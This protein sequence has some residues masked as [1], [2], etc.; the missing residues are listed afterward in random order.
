MLAR[1]ISLCDHPTIVL[2]K[3]LTLVGRQQRC[4]ARIGSWRV[5]RCHCCLVLEHGGLVV[6]DLDSTNGTLV[7]GQA[8]ESARL[9]HGDVLTIA[10]LRYRVCLEDPCE[11]A[12]ASASGEQSGGEPAHDQPTALEIPSLGSEEASPGSTRVDA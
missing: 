5:S 9:R 10:H 7:N 6:R 11:A 1:L 12:S 4:D 8:V 2:T 3:T